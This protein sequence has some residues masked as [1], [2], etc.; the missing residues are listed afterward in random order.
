MSQ[1]ILELTKAPNAG[2]VVAKAALRAADEIGVPAKT[3]AKSLGVSETTVSR[4]RN[5]GAPIKTESKEF[6]LAVMF[7]RLFRSLDAIAG[8]DRDTAKSWMVGHNTVLGDKP[9]ELIQTIAGLFN[10]VAYLD[11]RRAVV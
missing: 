11:S 7:I 8:G 2:A 10:V 9:I 4:W 1:N 6:E 5:D 3:L